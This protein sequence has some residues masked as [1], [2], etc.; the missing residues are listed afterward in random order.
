MRSTP[1]GFKLRSDAPGSQEL[2]EGPSLPVVLRP[3]GVMRRLPERF[4]GPIQYGLRCEEALGFAA[5]RLMIDSKVVGFSAG[6]PSTACLRRLGRACRRIPPP[7]LLV[8]IRRQRVPSPGRLH[9]PIIVVTSFAL[10]GRPV[11]PA[12][13]QRIVTE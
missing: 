3:A 1:E 8:G 13:G 12:V 4:V 6:S 2:S 5:M 7:D 10:A 9:I 11:A